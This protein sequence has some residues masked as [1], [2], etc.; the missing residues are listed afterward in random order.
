MYLSSFS[1][2]TIERPLQAPLEPHK[3]VRPSFPSR[4]LQEHT[5]GRYERSR[6]SASTGQEIEMLEPAAARQPPLVEG[7]RHVGRGSLLD[8]VQVAD[9]CGIGAAEAV[10]EFLRRETFLLFMFFGLAVL[11]HLALLLMTFI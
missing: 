1:S 11:A 4:S 10:V 9:V 3:Q 8:V 6:V 7:L 5:Y 2:Y